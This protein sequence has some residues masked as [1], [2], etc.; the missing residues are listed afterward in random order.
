MRSKGVLVFVLLGALTAYYV[1]SPIP[2]NI[3]E[4]WKLML[5]DSF[6]RSLSQLVNFAFEFTLGLS[7]EELSSCFCIVMHLK[8]AARSRLHGLEN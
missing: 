5:A 7:C 2:N 3:E 4:R 6:F 1:Y 8:V